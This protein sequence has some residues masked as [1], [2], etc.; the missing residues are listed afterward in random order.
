MSMKDSTYFIECLIE[1]SKKVNVICNIG[2]KVVL[3]IDC[4]SKGI[5][6]PSV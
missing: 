1:V 6:L 4:Y 5:L 3:H 2:G